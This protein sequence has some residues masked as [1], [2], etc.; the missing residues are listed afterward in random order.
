VTYGL[1]PLGE[2]AAVRVRA[3]AEWTA[4]RTPDVLTARATYDA[5]RSSTP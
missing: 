2:E 5:A 4:S 1:T 3:L